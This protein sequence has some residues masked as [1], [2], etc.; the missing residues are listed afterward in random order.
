MTSA[1]SG[2]AVGRTRT[3]TVYGRLPAAGTRTVRV[4]P[5]DGRGGGGASCGDGVGELGPASPAR[6][7]GADSDD[8][9]ALPCRPR[10]AHSAVTHKDIAGEEEAYLIRRFQAGDAV[11]GNTLLRAHDGLVRTWL[12]RMPRKVSAGLDE[13]DLLQEGRLGFLRAVEMFDPSAGANLSTYASHWIQQHMERFRQNHART[14]RVPVHVQAA[15]LGWRGATHQVTDADM[16]MLHG[17]VSLETLTGADGESTLGTMIAADVPNPERQIVDA[18]VDMK[19]RALLERAMVGLTAQMREV[20]ARRLLTDEPETLA[21]IA[22]SWGLT[23]RRVQQVE[24][25][26]LKKIKAA[27]VRMNAHKMSVDLLGVAPDD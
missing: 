17:S 13:D 8:S 9:E 4:L 19:R 6:L 20:V 7:P 3:I 24:A 25:K 22:E 23:R 27:L 15:A 10:R 2:I 11:A 14:I 21:E 26:V 18:D 1:V 5:E 16:A 12:R